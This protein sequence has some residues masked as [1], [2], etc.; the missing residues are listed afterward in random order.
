MLMAKICLKH[1]T[2]NPQVILISSIHLVHFLQLV[3]LQC[4]ILELSLYQSSPQDLISYNL[5]L[6][7]YGLCSSPLFSFQPEPYYILFL[8]LISPQV[9]RALQWYGQLCYILYLIQISAH[10]HT[11]HSRDLL[12][13]LSSCYDLL[14]SITPNSPLSSSALEH[15]CDLPSLH[16]S[17][18]Y[19]HSA[20]TLI[21]LF[22]C[23]DSKSMSC[24]IC[25]YVRFVVM[26]ILSFC[27]NNL[28]VELLAVS[29]SSLYPIHHCFQLANLCYLSSCAT[30]H[31]IQ[32]VFVF[33]L[34]LC[35]TC[36]RSKLLIVSYLL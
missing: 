32:L 36:H 9:F 15:S 12:Q 3:S 13:L 8:S 23:P 4:L 24:F 6:Q 35:P 2:V 25:N 26:S 5:F 31:C 20:P 1:F 19:P 18:G 29:N 10:F 14:F 34:S 27:P 28:C 7:P 16:F 11:Y 22:C 17:S 33:N 21:S 30:C